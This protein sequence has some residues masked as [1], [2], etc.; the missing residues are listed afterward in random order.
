[1]RGNHLCNLHACITH[2]LQKKNLLNIFINNVTSRKKNSTGTNL[3]TSVHPLTNI[4]MI[5]FFF[6]VKKTK[7]NLKANFALRRKCKTFYYFMTGFTI[8]TSCCNKA[9]SIS[10]TT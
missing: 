1:M 10:S 4:C 8:Q 9:R 3:Y 5:I 6:S 2:R 7:P